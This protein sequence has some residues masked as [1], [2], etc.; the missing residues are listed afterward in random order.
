[1]TGSWIEAQDACRSRYNSNL[2]SFHSAKESDF[3]RQ[4]ANIFRLDSVWIGLNKLDSADGNYEWV[5]GS[6]LTY[7]N[8]VIG[9]PS[10]G[11]ENCAAQWNSGLNWIDLPCASDYFLPYVCD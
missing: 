9:E 3:V 7:T 1:M 4:I 10:G 6:D 5:D 11:I 2:T 8:W